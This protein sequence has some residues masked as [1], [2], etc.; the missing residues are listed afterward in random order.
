MGCF[1]TEN[2][3]RKRK[4]KDPCPVCFLHKSMCLCASIPKLDL[5][6][7]VCL[8]IHRKEL[9]RT[10]NTGQLALNALTNSEM[11]V[12][13]SINEHLDLSQVLNSDYYPLL[14]FPAENA[15]EL[16]A[17]FVATIKKPILLIVPDGN[18]RQASKV[19]SRY[20]ELKDVPRV[21]ISTKNKNDQHLR[22]ESTEYGMATLQ[23]IA[24]AL[25]AIEGEAVQSELLKLY[26]LKLQKT[27]IGRGHLKENT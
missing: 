12:R 14:F 19:H 13:G 20:P 1:L 26:H 10:T 17:D 3:Q 7:R 16:T 9:K 25:G 22:K 11:K 6:T 15:I 4:T 8:V 24:Y 23:A 5:R 18:W 27:L 21:M 2:Y